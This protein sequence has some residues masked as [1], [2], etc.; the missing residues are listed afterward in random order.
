MRFPVTIRT[1][2]TPSNIHLASYKEWLGKQAITA[3]T[4][5][6]YHSRVKQFL[7]FIE[8]ANLD[9]QP[10]NNLDCMNEA[11]SMYLIFLKEA[12][13][14][15]KSINANVNALNSFSHFLGLKETQLKREHCYNKSTKILT[16]EE[17]RKFLCS[18]QEQDWV[19]DKALALV[20]FYTGLRIG[21]CARLDV[22]DVLINAASDTSAPSFFAVDDFGANDTFAHIKL[23]NGAKVPLNKVT[24]LALQQW[25]IE[26][27]KLAGAQTNS[28]LW[29][30][31][32]SDRLSISG[33]ACVIRRIGWQAQ[34]VVSAELLRR[35][36]LTRSTNHFNKKEL[37]ARCGNYISASTINRYGISLPAL[38][39]NM[40][41]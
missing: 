2:I 14:G 27:A 23:S 11:M 33:M 18:A 13:G 30:T 6:V 19:R 40:S 10:L 35:C 15:I 20:L 37:A 34:L 38:D 26:R 25:L 36:W 39:L 21:D 3:N 8:Y 4:Q 22:A 32:D 5:R 1:T 41:A 29:L 12:K 7:L 16:A 31:K 17:Q 9:D 28:A 24:V